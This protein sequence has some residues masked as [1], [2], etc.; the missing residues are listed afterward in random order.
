MRAWLAAL[1]FVTAVSEAEAQ[2][3]VLPVEPFVLTTPDYPVFGQSG[4]D[5]GLTPYLPSMSRDRRRG[6]EESPSSESQGRRTD[7]RCQTK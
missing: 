7:P 2:T 6:Q 4:V 5:C 1:V 3:G